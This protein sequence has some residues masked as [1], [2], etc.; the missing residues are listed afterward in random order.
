MFAWLYGAPAFSS[1]WPWIFGSLAVAL[2]FSGIDDLVPVLIC[3]GHSFFRK[4]ST[5][6]ITADGGSKQ[7]R[8][9][10]IFVPCWKE[11]DVIGNM[12]RHNLAAIRYRNFDFFLGVYP[13]DEG[14]YKVARELAHT[15]RNVHV[16]ACPHR[17]PTSKADCL[18][19]IYQRMLLVE[20]QET[21]RFDTVVLH[22]A[23]DLIHPDALQ[24]INNKRDSYG[25]VQVP[26][27]PLAT[28]FADFTHGIYCDEFAEYQMIDMPARQFSHSFIPSNGVGTGF[29]REILERLASERQNRIFDPASLTEDYETGVYIHQ[30][31][32]PQLFAGLTRGEKDFLATREYFPQAMR[33]AIRQRTR[34]VTGIA[35]QGWERDGW[36]G[37]WST[38]YW[39]WRDRKGLITNPLSLLTNIL[40]IAGLADWVD[41]AATHRT[42][43]FAVSNPGLVTLC[44]VTLLLQCFR[45]TLRAFCVARL[46]GLR[47]ALGVPLRVF[48]GNFVNSSASLAAMWRF[49]KARFH[50]R[51]LAWVKTEHA[52]P[53]REALQ[54]HRRE[55]T[56]VLVASGCISA[57]RLSVVQAGIPAEADLADFLLSNG[58]VSDED[59]C[60][61][62]SLQ[63][64]LPA[65]RIDARTVKTGIVRSL[66]A[67]VQKRFGIVPFRVHGGRLHVAGTRP[68][69]SKVLEELRSFTRLPVE[70]QLVTHG[71]Y[72]ELQHLR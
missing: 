33:S 34:W 31:G 57:E 44:W 12:V 17:G 62:I 4:K 14:T 53:T 21:T 39:F 69:Q 16:A 15:F 28:P 20:K 56:E 54:P 10:A 59:L 63:C 42:W 68:P 51:P 61:A 25:M 9:I 24:L 67:H 43:A 32:Y 58:L 46:Y 49:A 70:F 22:D 6:D 64:G 48:H 60:Y 37:P 13:N 1:V 41:A 40:F 7:E 38:R 8:K 11:S 50:G 5:T 19:W 45:L 26:V 47:F 29:G 35:L 52:Y 2:V 65:A 18:N 30:A 55:L 27:L 71:N 3:G 72:E 23:E 36:R 66:P